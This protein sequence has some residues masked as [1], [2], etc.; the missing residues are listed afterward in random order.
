MEV[1]EYALSVIR[2]ETLGGKL[3]P[4][5]DGLT[6]D[7]PGAG[8]APS[9]PGRP[10]GLE[11]V[12]G[13]RAKT[14]S[15]EGLTDPAQRVRILHAFA[16][17]ELQAAELFAWALLAWPDAPRAFRRGLL[18]ILAEEQVHCR[19]YVER[20]EE[21]GG[22]FGD[23]PVSGYFWGKVPELTT[24]LRFVCAMALTFESANLDHAADHE[25]AARA[26]GDERTAEIL[27]RVHEDEIGHVRFGWRWLE[28]WK[29]P[30]RTMAEAYRENV[31]WPL[32]PA[33][34]RGP[35]LHRESRAA[36]GMDETFVRMLEEADAR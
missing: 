13:S 36:A 16:N 23:H 24:P 10:P 26:C 15:I 19:L 6:D 21:L 17:H 18:R 14:P 2:A 4:P 20:L 9:A 3:A 11:I 34:A 35:V 27:R 25:A 22:R 31:T 33:L 30:D 5:P 7:D 28:R 29:E 8:D 32:R 1:R 12:P